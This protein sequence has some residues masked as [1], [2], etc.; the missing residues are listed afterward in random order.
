MLK[1]FKV[2]KVLTM[3]YKGEEDGKIEERLQKLYADEKELMQLSARGWISKGD[4]ETEHRALRE[5]IEA[6]E[7]KA[8]ELRL[9]TFSSTDCKPITSFEIEKLHRFIKKVT[10]RD[11]VVTFE[12]YNGVEISREYTNGQHGNIQD[13]VREH[14]IRRII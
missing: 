1:G 3:D 12:F 8:E 2:I 10:L 5:E 11:W 14:R 13:W 4:F 7:S 9:A 6:L